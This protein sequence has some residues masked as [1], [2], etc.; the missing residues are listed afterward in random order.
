MPLSTVEK[1]LFLK[2]VPLFESIPGEEVV[3]LVPIIQEVEIPRGETFIRC[4]DEGNC[5]YIVVEGE[6]EA[7]LPDGVIRSMTSRE[8]IGEL[9]VL[10]EQPRTA[11]CTATT[12]V[13]ALRIDKDDFWELMNRQPRRAIDIMKVIV[14]RYVAGGGQR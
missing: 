6:V 7:A 12:D 3:D 1:V 2:S 14:D 5:L 11:D 8:A 10:T 4:G 9:A 13:V